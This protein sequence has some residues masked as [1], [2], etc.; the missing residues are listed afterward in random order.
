MQDRNA[1]GFSRREVMKAGAVALALPT[2]ASLFAGTLS[3]CGSGEQAAAPGAREPAVPPPQKPAE[4]KPAAP[5]QP[6]SP[7]PAPTTGGGGD[8]V[9][10]IPA[11]A[12]LVSGLQYVS[13]SQ[14]P[15]QSCRNCQFFS[16]EEGD[17][18]KCQLFAQGRVEA[19]GWCAS[20]A[21][22]VATT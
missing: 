3:G 22:R 21:K 20:W 6:A 16:A 11:M 5:A 4:A 13:K 10:E 8:L 1:Q 17:R 14:K 18:G 9:T 2:L 12:A 15:D 19:A 7:G